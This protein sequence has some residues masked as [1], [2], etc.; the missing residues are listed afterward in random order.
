MNR[1]RADQG[2]I[3]DQCAKLS[4][5]FDPAK[6][7][8][9]GGIQF[10]YHRGMLAVRIVDQHIYRIARQ[11]MILSPVER[12]KGMRLFL[13]FLF[14][15]ETIQVLNHIV[16]DLIQESPDLHQALIFGLDILEQV[17]E[18]VTCHFPI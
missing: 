17:L 7:V 6:Q 16:L 3:S 10:Q 14:R 11:N 8:A 4:L 12:L 2:E 13:F 5:L 9:V 15:L 1:S 18:S